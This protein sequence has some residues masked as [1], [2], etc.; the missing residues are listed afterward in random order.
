M[1][2]AIE[3]IIFCATF[4]APSSSPPRFS[5]ITAN[6]SPPRRGDRV[7]GAHAGDEAIGHA[8]Q[9]LVARV[10]A[11]RVV[12]GLEAVEVDEHEGEAAVH[13]RGIHHRLL[14]A[15]V[16]QDA[17]GQPRERI[18][19]GEVLGALLRH[20]A[21]G[22]V[23]RGPVHA[24]RAPV[25]IALRDLAARMHPDPL[26]RG[27]G[28]AVLA[29]EFLAHALGRVGESHAE[30]LAVLGVVP[31]EHL[32]GGE[33]RLV[34]RV[35][36]HLGPVL[37]EVHAA[38]MQVPVPEREARARESEVQALLGA[39]HLLLG[40]LPQRDVARH[41]QHADLAADGDRPTGEVVGADVAGA[42]DDLGLQRH[43]ACLLEHRAHRLDHGGAIV[44]RDE[45][46]GTHRADL[47]IRVADRGGE[48]RIPAQHAAVGGDEVEA[49]GQV[50]Q[51]RRGELA[52]LAQALLG[53][54]AAPH[55]GLQEVAWA[56]GRSGR[57]L[58]ARH[59]QRGQVG[60]GAALVGKEHAR[61]GIDHGERA[62]HPSI[63]AHHRD[64]A[65]EA[66]MRRTGDE[67]VLAPLRGRSVLDEE[68]LAAALLQREAVV[69]AELREPHAHARAQ[70]LAPGLDERDPGDREA[71][72][73][74]RAPDELVERRLRDRGGRCGDGVLH[75]ISQTTG[76]WSEGRSR[77]RGARS[78]V[79]ARQ[80]AASAG[81]SRMWSMRRP[82][83]RRNAF[84]R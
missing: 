66:R 71:A 51:H 37:V 24:A 43:L 65:D 72:H 14:E 63:G 18:A 73:I 6:S 62:Q 45:I 10:V 4:C 74:G 26:A 22:D 52:L 50:L 40:A 68:R 16:Q 47:G 17:V 33:S 29:V 82:I 11:E 76:A 46:L 38:R 36:Q 13:A 49:P 9:Q 32:V 35:A 28:H 25:G 5:R 53:F 54:L 78:M 21:L 15:V 77:P 31:G 27:V 56:R 57:R 55:L 59:H 19:R 34:R 39:H 3:A 79:H 44:R 75:P 70:A 12:D 2:A 83:L 30:H 60:E 69:G 84:I 80:A 1:G 7:G 20:A 23:G 64:H 48:G 67:G 8:L 61:T 42:V 81:E 41:P 58:D